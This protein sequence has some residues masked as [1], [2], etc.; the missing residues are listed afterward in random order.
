MSCE[1]VDRCQLGSSTGAVSSTSTDHII[2]Y[3]PPVPAVL[4]D[5]TKPRPQ[6]EIILAGNQISNS[7]VDGILVKGVALE[8]PRRWT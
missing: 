4:G 1:N 2:Q 8:R 6:G 5:V 3:N 7:S